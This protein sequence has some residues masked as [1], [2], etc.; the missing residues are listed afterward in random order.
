MIWR[1]I[2][3]LAN[4]DSP[5]TLVTSRHWWYTGQKIQTAI[6]ILAVKV[7]FYDT[8]HEFW[9]HTYYRLKILL[10]SV[11]ITRTVYR[12]LGEINSQEGNCATSVLISTIYNL[13][14]C[15]GFIYGYSHDRSADLA[16]GKE[17]DRSWEYINR[18]QIY[19][20]RNWE[21]GRAVSFLGIHKS[22]FLCSAV[23]T[24]YTKNHMN[25]EQRRLILSF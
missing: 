6:H 24:V 17:V 3:S 10:R 15:E 18:S 1:G 12:K 22:D 23:R 5:P 2:W 11:H 19:K 21:W 9:G 14:I 25:I 20:C 8:C 16:E 13:Y 4:G 7:K